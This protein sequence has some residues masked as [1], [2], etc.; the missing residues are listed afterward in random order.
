MKRSEMK[1]ILET[2]FEQIGLNMTPEI[3]AESVMRMIEDAGMQPPNITLDQLIPGSVVR[4]NPGE[5]QHYYACWEPE[6]EKK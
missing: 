2:R 5:H 1:K 6:D 4:T 3:L